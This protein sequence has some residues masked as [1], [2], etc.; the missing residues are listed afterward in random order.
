MRLAMAVSI[1]LL[2]LVHGCGKD[3]TAPTATDA[4]L[5]VLRFADTAFAHVEKAGSVWAVRGQERE[6]VLRYENYGSYA[7]EPYLRFRIPAQALLR[8]P[9]GRSYAPGDSV[10]IT[11]TVDAGGRYLFEFE[12][13]GLAFDPAHPA[14]LTVWYEWADGDLDGDGD[15]DAVDA[16]LEDGLHVWRRET[17]GGEWQRLGTVRRKE[18]VELQARVTGFTGFVIATRNAR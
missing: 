1:A 6:L 15:E 2:M 9:A 12:P 13:S 5:I 16:E 18:T 11:V 17:L 8:D 4:E 7:G 10:Q 3:P 14:E